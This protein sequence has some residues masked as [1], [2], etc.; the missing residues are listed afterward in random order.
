MFM[1]DIMSHRTTYISHFSGSPA[2]GEGTNGLVD[3]RPWMS[4][5]L[6]TRG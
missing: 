3:L 4:M 1:A 6:K 5:A 2:T